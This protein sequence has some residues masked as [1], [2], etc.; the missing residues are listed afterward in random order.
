VLKPCGLL[1]SVFTIPIFFR[2]FVVLPHP[3][4]LPIASPHG[5]SEFLIMRSKQ[6]FMLS[7][8]LPITGTVLFDKESRL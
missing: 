7:E 8:P 1:R 2:A 5:L 6:S 3:K 4:R